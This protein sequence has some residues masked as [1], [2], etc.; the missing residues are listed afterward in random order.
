MKD[1]PVWYRSLSEHFKLSYP[2]LQS[3]ARIS[4]LRDT[5]SNSPYVPVKI[6]CREDESLA[7]MQTETQ[8]SFPSYFRQNSLLSIFDNFSKQCESTMRKPASEVL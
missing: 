5:N 6:T 7:K 1:H 2:C 4:A 8:L 3:P